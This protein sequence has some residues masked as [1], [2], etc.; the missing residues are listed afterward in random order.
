MNEFLNELANMM[1]MM[2][3]CDQLVARAG[4]W[5][6]EVNTRTYRTPMEREI[7]FTR[8]IEPEVEEE[9]ELDVISEAEEG[10]ENDLPF[11]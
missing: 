11:C 7:T 6:I 3:N 5:T 4:R 9:P 2:E 8:V 10:T 1:E